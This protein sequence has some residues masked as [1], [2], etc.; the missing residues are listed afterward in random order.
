MINESMAFKLH[1][2]ELLELQKNAAEFQQSTSPQD[3][4]HPIEKLE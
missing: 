4:L 1:V 2:L 3:G